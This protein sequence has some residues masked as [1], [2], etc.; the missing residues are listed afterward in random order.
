MKKILIASKNEHKIKE[1]KAILEDLNITLLDLNDLNDDEDVIE[2][3]DTFLA[4]AYKKAI[5]YARKHQMLTLSDD[6]G[7]CVEALGYKPGVHSKRYSGFGDHENNIKLLKDVQHEVNKKAFFK[8]VIVLCHS[9]GSFVHFDGEL[10]GIII[11]Q[12]KGCHG[13]GY[14]PIFYLEKQR[15]TLAEIPFNEKNK[16]SHRRIALNKLK[17]YIHENINNK[18]HPWSKG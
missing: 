1:I 9:D 12:S 10:H 5:T 7:L 4:N 17:E 6:S 15:K 11:D 16:I 18:R 13:F 2:D 8:A 14:D 3:Q